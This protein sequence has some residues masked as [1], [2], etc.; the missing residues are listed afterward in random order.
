MTQLD[1]LLNAAQVQLS[2]YPDAFGGNLEGLQ[3]FLS[4][5]PEGAVGNVHILPF[6][7]SSADR[8]FAPLTYFQ[9]VSSAKPL[10]FKA[11][12]ACRLS[13]QQR[14]LALIA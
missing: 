4:L 2:T 5:L 12:F 6:Y 10:A 1:L 13:V 7:P 14:A 3:K 11:S 8:G 9:V